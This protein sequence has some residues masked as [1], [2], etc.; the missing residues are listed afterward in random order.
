MHHHKSRHRRPSQDV[1]G[2]SPGADIPEH[3]DLVVSAQRSARQKLKTPPSTTATSYPS[4]TTATCSSPCH[5]RQPN[6]Q[7]QRAANP[8]PHRPHTRPAPRL[9]TARAL[10]PLPRNQQQHPTSQPRTR[11]PRGPGPR[12]PDPR[13]FRPSRPRRYCRMMSALIRPRSE[14]F[15]P[16]A[17]PRPARR[18]GPQVSHQGGWRHGGCC[19]T[20]LAGL[21]HPPAVLEHA[22]DQRNDRGLHG[23]GQCGCPQALRPWSCRS[24]S[25]SIRFPSRLHACVMLPGYQGG[26]WW[27]RHVVAC[28]G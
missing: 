12:Q 23:P 5:P 14:T 22:P 2:G 11:R 4:A 27:S 17:W 28:G 1:P 8:K 24:G 19:C 7:L 6:H 26:Q 21:R 9:R 3:D 10:H 25:V 18:C 16:A 20:A 15:R 13:Q